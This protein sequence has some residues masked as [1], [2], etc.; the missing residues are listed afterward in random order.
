V[1]RV[2]REIDV[3]RSASEVFE[4]LID[5]EQLPR[6][7][8]AVSEAALESPPPIAVGSRIRIVAN[9]A[10]QRTV[11]TGTISELDQPT[12]IGLVAKAGSADVAGS[13][14]ITPTGADACR[15]RVATTIKLGGMLR[16]VEG[17][18]RSRIEAEAPSAAAA[19][20]AWLESDEV[21]AATSSAADDGQTTAR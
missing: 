18:A 3:A 8:P 9:V 20:K 13:V 16:F 1:I 19:V 11:A 6:W 15:V 21:P 7:Q 17:V 4:R 10:G 12:R 14:G 5:I 2:E